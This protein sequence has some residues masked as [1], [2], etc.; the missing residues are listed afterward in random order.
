MEGI[1]LV[2]VKC[3]VLGAALSI[4]TQLI[5]MIS[6]LPPPVLLGVFLALGGVLTPFGIWQAMEAW[7]PGGFATTVFGAGK[8]VAE[9]AGAAAHGVWFVPAVIGTLFFVVVMLA[10]LVGEIMHAR[11]AK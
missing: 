6:K 4:V 7:A 3:F 11:S 10:C 9:S 8:A 5:W 1:V 2:L